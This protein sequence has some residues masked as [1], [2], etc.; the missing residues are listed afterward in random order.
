MKRVQLAIDYTQ[1]TPH[2]QQALKRVGFSAADIQQGKALYE[3]VQML[4]VAQKQEYGDR[5]R[6]TDAL[7]EARRQ[8]R[9]QYMRHLEVARLALKD[10]RGVWNTLELSGERKANL[11]GWLAQAHTF[12]HNVGLVQATLAK[13]NLPEAELQQGTSMIEAVIEAYH[14]R[15]KE[16]TEAQVATRQR[17]EILAQL[18]VWMR[19]FTMSAKLAFADDPNTLKGLGVVSKVGV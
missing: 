6:A 12:Y 2:V 5:Y 9:A 13:Y 10:Q 4:N 15:Q 8:A 18:K 1:R 14:V 16:G 11:F 3:H 19:R 17:N 7:I